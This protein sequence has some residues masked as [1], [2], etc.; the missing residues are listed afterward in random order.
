MF[1]SDESPRGE[2]A[3]IVRQEPKCFDAYCCLRGSLLRA[4][5]LQPN[6][7]PK[8]YRT[9]TKVLLCT[10]PS[11]TSYRG[12]SFLFPGDGVQCV[13]VSGQDAWTGSYR[14]PRYSEN[15]KLSA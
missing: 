14:M 9:V 11:T 12:L 7:A 4:P 1:L 2:P 13:A 3:Y 15:S 6:K 5:R 10:Q 8:R